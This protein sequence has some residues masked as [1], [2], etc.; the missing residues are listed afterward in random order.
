MWFP[1]VWLKCLGPEGLEISS[2]VS[3][4]AIMSSGAERSDP[5]RRRIG[6]CLT[7]WVQTQFWK[8][9]FLLFLG[10]FFLKILKNRLGFYNV[11]ENHVRDPFRKSS[12]P[13]AFH[14]QSL[15]AG[16]FQCLL[17]YLTPKDSQRGSCSFVYHLVMRCAS[18]IQWWLTL[19]AVPTFVNKASCFFSMS[20]KLMCWT[21][22][23]Y[24]PVIVQFGPIQGTAWLHALHW[25]K[26]TQSWPNMGPLSSNVIVVFR[27]LRKKVF[28]IKRA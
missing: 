4:G 27:Q 19:P 3:F 11:I 16:G 26:C 13:E 20:K 7:A 1:A 5:W 23:N 17:R 8:S 18:Y 24:F 6:V 12:Y 21:C 15:G 14:C 10:K 9:R 25:L 28:R 2:S 22:T